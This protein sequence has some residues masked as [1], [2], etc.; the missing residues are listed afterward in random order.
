MQAAGMAACV[1]VEH[2]AF[3]AAIGP[4]N[5]TVAPVPGPYPD[6]TEFVT[7]C[8]EVRGCKVGYIPAGEGLAKHRYFLPNTGGA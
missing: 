1:E 6:T 5:V 7:P 2:A 4:Q 8:G 3:Y